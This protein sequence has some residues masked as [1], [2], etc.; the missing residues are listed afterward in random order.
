MRV[1]DILK[2]SIH[3]LVGSTVYFMHDSKI[4]SGKVT[5]TDMHFNVFVAERYSIAQK[6]FFYSRDELISHLVNTEIKL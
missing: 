2:L 1:D 3:K 4:I 6:D 5:G